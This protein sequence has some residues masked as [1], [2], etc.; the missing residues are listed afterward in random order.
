MPSI[1]QRLRDLEAKTVAVEDETILIVKGMASAED[2]HEIRAV[3]IGDV[4]HHR[5]DGESEDAFKARLPRSGRYTLAVE[6][7][8]EQ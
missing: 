1:E 2:D 6:V 3:R 5:R 4:V 7:V 8:D